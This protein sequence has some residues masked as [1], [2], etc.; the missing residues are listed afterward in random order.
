MKEIKGGKELLKELAE[1]TKEI[2]KSIIKLKKELEQLEIDFNAREEKFTLDEIKK[3]QSMQ[4]DID[5]TKKI[6][7]DL[8]N[9]KS[10]LIEENSKEVADKIYNLL[11]ADRERKIQSKLEDRQK[12]SRL[13]KEAELL[14]EKMAEDDK[15]FEL[16]ERNYVNQAQ[17]YLSKV[18]DGKIPTVDRSSDFYNLK[19]RLD[20]EG[21]GRH[22]IMK[23]TRVDYYKSKPD[24]AIEED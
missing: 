21:V 6:I 20:L 8:E 14:N 23:P 15:D 2:D 22:E 18:H 10:E 19:H 7:K 13:R 11:M 9:R 4:R 5:I 1:P 17:P 12:I 3:T 24:Y 16:Q